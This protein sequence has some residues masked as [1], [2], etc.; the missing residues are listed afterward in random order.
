MGGAVKDYGPLRNHNLP[1]RISLV[2]SPA[3]D[4]QDHI[5]MVWRFSGSMERRLAVLPASAA[6]RLCLRAR[7]N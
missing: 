4:R 1:E 6:G 7:L 5:A 3:D 2:S